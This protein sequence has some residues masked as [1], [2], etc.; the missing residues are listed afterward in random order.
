MSLCSF[1]SWKNHIRGLFFLVMVIFFSCSKQNL[2]INCEDCIELEP[3]EAVINIKLDTYES[4]SMPVN[5]R[6]YQGFIEDSLLQSEYTIDQ[7][8]LVISVAI[9]KQYTITATYTR[10]NI[11]YTAIDSATPRVRYEPD[12]CDT[13]CYFIYDNK[14]DLRIRYTQ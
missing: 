6:V 11:K 9:N 10:S 4:G 13:P 14:I 8:P 1:N 12:K 3:V 5:I 2:F 7:F